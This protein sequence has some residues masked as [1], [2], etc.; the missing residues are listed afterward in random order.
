MP[1]PQRLLQTQGTD[2]HDL[3][4]RHSK[5]VRHFRLGEVRD[6]PVLFL[7]V[8]GMDLPPDHHDEIT[9]IRETPAGSR[10]PVGQGDSLN[11]RLR[12]SPSDKN[13]TGDDRRGKALSRPERISIHLCP[14]KTGWLI[15][16]NEFVLR[17]R[18]QW[19]CCDYKAK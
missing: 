13:R 5:M 1:F 16:L 11:G 15:H 10:N 6:N 2:L 9:L 17:V 4:Q 19:Q 3:N 18:Q 14:E 7:P 12:K 8:L